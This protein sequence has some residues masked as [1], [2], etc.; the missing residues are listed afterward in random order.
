MSSYAFTLGAMTQVDGSDV[1]GWVDRARADLDAELERLGET[2]S[3]LRLAATVHGQRIRMTV[4]KGY[5]RVRL[6]CDGPDRR[7]VQYLADQLEL[8][9]IAEV[10]RTLPGPASRPEANGDAQQRALMEMFRT[11]GNAGRR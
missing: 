5:G 9:V 7:L 2:D 11:L 4:Y 10:V 3:V 6:E 8:S 1:A